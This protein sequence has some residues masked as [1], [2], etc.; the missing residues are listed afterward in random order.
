MSTSGFTPICPRCGYDQTGIIDT[1]TDSCPTEGVCTECGDTLDWSLVFDPDRETKR[2]Y[3]E[4]APSAIRAVLRRTLPTIGML[5]LPSRF[6]KRL[7]TNAK[8]DLWMLVRWSIGF[9][10]TLY[11]LTTLVLVVASFAQ[12]LYLTTT[13]WGQNQPAPGSAGTV[14]GS[15]IRAPEAW[16]EAFGFAST[17]PMSPNRAASL[18]IDADVASG[19]ISVSLFAIVSTLVWLMIM[20]A[21]PTTRR[22]A[23]L[24]YAHIFRAVMIGLTLPIAFALLARLLDP[25]AEVLINWRGWSGWAVR[26]WSSY[27]IGLIG[28]YASL[29]WPQWFWVSAI[30]TGWRVRPSWLL[31]LL[32]CVASLIGG[33]AAVLHVSLAMG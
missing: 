16:F 18:W 1:W 15:M 13:Y 12:R 4:H 29:V 33:Y 8:L 21:V 17:F 9:L 2:W 14:L 31:A 30:R 28:L 32:G 10:G 27:P 3:T 6:W 20:G 5:V 7:D 19:A 22:L 25:I 26:R 11:V 23:K 24:R